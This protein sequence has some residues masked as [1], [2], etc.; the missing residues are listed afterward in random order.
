ML[1]LGVRVKVS[2]MFFQIFRVEIRVQV[3]ATEIAPKFL[4]K[5]PK[6]PSNLGYN[7]HFGGGGGYKFENFEI[8]GKKVTDLFLTTKIGPRLQEKRYPISLSHV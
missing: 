7:E 5:N 8:S 4:G 2:N 6:K 3:Y 1:K